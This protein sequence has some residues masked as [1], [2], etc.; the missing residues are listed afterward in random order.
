MADVEEVRVVVD[1]GRVIVTIDDAVIGLTPAVAHRLA[2]E[3]HTAAL[4]VEHKTPKRRP[5][6]T[7]RTH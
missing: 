6:K 1:G 4:T 3:L 7:G 2:S 5:P